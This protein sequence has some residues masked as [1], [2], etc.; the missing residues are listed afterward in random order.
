VVFALLV[1]LAWLALAEAE[2]PRLFTAAAGASLTAALI[3]SFASYG[4]WEEW[5]LSTLWFALYAILVMGR[6]ARADAGR[7]VTSARPPSF[8]GGRSPSRSE[9]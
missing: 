6:I 1:A 5:W 3:A 2:W 4:V 7:C 8:T 9:R